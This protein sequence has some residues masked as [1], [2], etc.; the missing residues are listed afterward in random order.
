MA[1]SIGARR[2][3]GR[4]HSNSGS[5]AAD[6][7]FVSV[8]CPLAGEHPLHTHVE[9]RAAP[10][11]TTVQRVV[12]TDASSLGTG[13]LYMHVHEVTDYRGEALI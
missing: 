4:S 6:P 9:T 3:P 2:C 7:V 13:Q 12:V 1:G 8:E 5:R 11:R 10:S